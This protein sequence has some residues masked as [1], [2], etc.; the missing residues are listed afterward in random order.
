[1][2][3]IGLIPA[4]LESQRLARKLLLKETGKTIIQHVYERVVGAT[5]LSGV[6]VA[7]DSDEIRE[8][9]EGF[10][11]QVVLTGPC[12]SGTDRLAQACRFPPC[13]E[14]EIEGVVNIQGD[15]PEIALST[16]NKVAHA[17]KEKKAQ[18]VTAVRWETE[19]D[20]FNDPNLVKVVL[21]QKQEALYFS[22]SPLPY[23]RH[24]APLGFYSHLGIYGYTRDFLQK[25]AQLPQT[26]LEKLEGLEQLRVLEQGYSIAVVF[27]EEA[28]SGIDTRED[29]D[30]FLL[31]YQKGK[32]L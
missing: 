8:E 4:R 5:E 17:L 12:H 28:S 6:W 31:R 21:N 16:V 32:S 7:T 11:G 23:P 9:V 30:R 13:N 3:V 25:Y 2:K 1:M 27:V 10:G 19:L 24:F 14:P 29:Y 18:M 15:E 26:P 20:R 22:R